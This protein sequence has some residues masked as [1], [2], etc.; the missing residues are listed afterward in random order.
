MMAAE[1]A[2]GGLR[3]R[4]MTLASLASLPEL[5]VAEL[6]EVRQLIEVRKLITH[7]IG[8]VDAHIIAS[9]IIVEAPAAV[10]TDDEGLTRIAEKHG[11]L[12]KPPFATARSQR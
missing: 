9:L 8:P 7:G 11:F 1:L 12:P 2:L 5:P 10:W 6:H 3:D 4:R